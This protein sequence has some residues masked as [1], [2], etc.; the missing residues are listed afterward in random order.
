LL[1]VTVLWE[2]YGESKNYN[3]LEGHTNAVLDLKW[4]PDGKKVGAGGYPSG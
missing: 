4:A 1:C 3:V 2:V